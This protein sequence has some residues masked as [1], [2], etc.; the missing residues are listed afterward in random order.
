MKNLLFSVLALAGIC[1]GQTKEDS[2][3]FRKISDEILLHGQAYDLLYDLTQN[4]GHRLSGSPE[5]E[6]AT[7]WAE[8]QLKGAGADKVW[9]QETLVPVW[10]RGKESLKYKT[11][12]GEWKDIN[13]LSLGNSE[14]TGKKD[15]EGE[16]IRVT[17]F[18]EF[19]K[20]PAETVKGKIVFFDYHFPQQYVE[21]FRGYGEAY[22]Y[23]SHTASAV[24]EKGGKFAII[25]SVSTGPD[26]VPHTGTMNYDEKFA[27]IPAVAV[28]NTTADMLAGL[29]KNQKLYLKLNSDCGMQPEKINHSVIGEIKGKDDK[30]ITVGGHL[31]SWDVGEGA[32]DDGAGIVQTIEILRTF[33]KLGIQPNHTIR[34]VCFAN[35]ENG[36]RGG[37]KYAEEAKS[38]NETHLFALE[39]DAGGF[40]P[41]GISLDMDDSK[42]KQIQSWLPL[43]E[44]YGAYLLIKG[45][46]GVDIN[47]LKYTMG[48]PV[49]GL[50][51]DS[52][53]YFDIHHSAADTFDKV[54]KR[55]LHLGAIVM[56]QMIYMIDKYWK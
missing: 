13:F 31:D 54:N 21:T 47:P 56:A 6:K 9:L 46:G 30:I 35:E 42:I 36:A 1:F 2:I 12:N 37:V 45:Y 44:P 55:E 41:R 14:G 39:S 5:Y 28:G 51:P 26:D 50:V 48:V 8:Q 25:R 18:D 20:L 27:K 19:N 33:K 29:I 3:Q 4:I 11:G 23:R 49:A 24:A 34:F 16:V 17:N 38:K 10:H 7:L 40:S 32:H 15:V 22:I 43:F 53:R 52:Q